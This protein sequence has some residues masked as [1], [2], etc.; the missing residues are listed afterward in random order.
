MN[1]LVD[2]NSY[3]VIP[4]DID[5][6]D[7]SSSRSTSEQGNRVTFEMGKNKNVFD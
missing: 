4:F 6:S 5:F 1:R 7:G 3:N 2:P